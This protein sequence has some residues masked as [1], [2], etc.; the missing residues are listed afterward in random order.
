M[1]K[2]KTSRLL[3]LMLALAIALLSFTAC[4]GTDNGD[5]VGT[6]RFVIFDEGATEYV[7]DLSALGEGEGLM[8]VLEYLA[9]NE[10]LS[11][12]V[13]DGGYGA[14]LTALG[15]LKES[16]AE[17]KYLY[18]YTSVEADFDVSAYAMTVDYAGLTLTSSGVGISQ[19]TLTDGAVIYI[20]YIVY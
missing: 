3:A 14:Y 10:E 9:E 6:I 20:T 13:T 5:E 17:G 2:L 19:M 15:S 8:P 11:Y 7:V 12:T 1:L 16:A 18:V 4:G